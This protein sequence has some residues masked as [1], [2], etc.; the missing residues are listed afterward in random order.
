MPYTIVEKDEQYCVHKKNEDGSAGE[1]VKCHDS[2]SEAKEHMDA[3]YANVEESKSFSVDSVEDSVVLPGQEIFEEITKS[4]LGD[5]LEALDRHKD[6]LR[7]RDVELLKTV[8][9]GLGQVMQVVSPV[10]N[11]AVKSLGSDLIGGY[12]VLFGSEER[13]DLA[14]EFFTP[15]TKDMLSIFKSMGAIPGI[16]LHGYDE[17][18]KEFIFGPVIK[19]EEKEAGVWWE[20]Q[21][22]NHEIYREYVE[23]LLI[24]ERLYSSSGALPAAKRVNKD[25]GEITRWPIMEM[26]ITSTPMEFRM[27]DVPLGNIEKAYKAIGVELPG[28]LIDRDAEE[29]KKIQLQVAVHRELLKLGK[30]K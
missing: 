23:P 17:T 4:S 12:G 5:F 29:A 16:I 28:M 8:Y 11:S 10:L 15:N 22:K 6:D 13:K 27:L 2:E 21:I 3:L 24:R 20:A 14:Q 18:L 7:E 30:L 1:V 19:M 25:T 26:T 9:K